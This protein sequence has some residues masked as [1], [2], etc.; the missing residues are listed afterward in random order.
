MQF[1][2]ILAHYHLLSASHHFPPLPDRLIY[3][4]YLSRVTSFVCVKKQKSLTINSKNSQSANVNAFGK[5]N[6]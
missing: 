5:P 1:Y 3:D 6:E 4:V 2:G